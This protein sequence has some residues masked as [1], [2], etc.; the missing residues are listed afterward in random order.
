V[1]DSLL[2]AEAPAARLAAA[3]MVGWDG[4]R[5]APTMQRALG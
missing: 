1:K 4:H 2:W 3:V 5:G